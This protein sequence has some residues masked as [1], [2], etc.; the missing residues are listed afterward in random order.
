MNAHE[1]TFEYLTTLVRTL[2][3]APIGRMKHRA[4]Q[5]GPCN[6]VG[7]GDAKTATPSTYRPVGPTCPDGSSEHVGKCPYLG[8]GC[9]AQGGNVARHQRRAT[10]EVDA[11]VRATAIGMVWARRTDKL[12][13]LHVSGDFVLH[14][15]V[16][17]RYIV[18]IGMLADIVNDVSGKPRGTPVAWSYT[19]I[20]QRTFEAYRAFLER[21]GVIVR[22]SDHTGANGAI[23]CEFGALPQLKADKGVKYVKC[24]AQLPQKKTCADCTLCWTLPSH[25]V[26]FEP[27]GAAKRKAGRASLAILQG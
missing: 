13:R 4:E 9:Y 19:H 12:C 10:D 22:Y 27:H 6:P 2:W 20:P 21:K 3:D 7:D 17:H 11:S 15:S 8:N 1:N 23:V 18:Q 16:D 14:G 24:P 26:V 5:W 25:T